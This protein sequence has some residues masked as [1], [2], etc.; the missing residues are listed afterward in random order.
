MWRSELRI[1]NLMYRGIT[2]EEAEI[3]NF[4]GFFFQYKDENIIM[5]TLPNFPRNVNVRF[6]PPLCFVYDINKLST[7]QILS[8]RTPHKMWNFIDVGDKEIAIPNLTLPA[9][10]AAV[11]MINESKNDNETMYV[12]PITLNGEHMNMMV[13]YERKAFYFEPHNMEK[14][15]KGDILPYGYAQKFLQ[16]NFSLEF[17]HLSCPK[18]AWQDQDRFCQTWS[19]WYMFL[20]MNGKNDEVA[21]QFMS[22][23]GI[24]GLKE[25]SLNIYHTVPVKLGRKSYSSLQEMV[26]RNVREIQSL[27]GDATQMIFTVK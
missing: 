11:K 19:H 25:F 18:L 14:Y 10:K 8:D 2:K 9:S 17:D 5:A 15:R 16:T 7:F 23:K 3:L 24:E 4:M 6:S 21:R 20:R 26:T 12:I 13:I 22:A 27:K 1:L